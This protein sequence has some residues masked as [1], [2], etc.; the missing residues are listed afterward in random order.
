MNATSSTH[1]LLEMCLK[2]G[3]DFY[4]F[5]MPESQNLEFGSQKNGGSKSY[6]KLDECLGIKGFVFAPFD[7]DANS[8]AYFIER[9]ISDLTQISSAQI[10]LT[11]NAKQINVQPEHISSKKEY[12]LQFEEIQKFIQNKNL[13][14]LVLSRIELLA[15][16][17][18][19]DAVKSFLNLNA[20]YPEAFSFMVHIK[21]AGLWIGATPEQLLTK[22]S[23]TLESI[24]L[25]GTKK[26]N[27][28]DLNQIVWNKK[29]ILEQA[30]VEEYIDSVFKKHKIQNIKK[31]ETHTSRAG[32]LAHLK[33]IF[34]AQA[35]L[36]FLKLA[37]LIHDLH[38]TP[39]V[40]GLP[41]DEALQI[42]RQLEHHNREY[43]T[44]YLGP[45]EK[46]GNLSLF[47]N[48]RSMKVKENT[49]ALYVG[50]GI[51]DKSKPEEEWEET[52]LKAQTLL[53]VIQA[54]M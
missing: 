7:Q 33:T 5:S 36:S 53:D 26:C 22:K 46:N 30:C 28:F 14:K 25:A 20:A 9:E 4:V 21:Q 38:P 2:K 48:L 8:K 34:K 32:K 45:I 41:K 24:A 27:S 18:K 19:A 49:M 43:Y 17:G 3:I 44:G 13:S 23:S 1:H 35:R 47:V 54:K 6:T 52:C 50:G 15:N 39:A 11:E 29:E 31:T 42:I 37:E 51:T 10:N 16:K 12:I 40:C